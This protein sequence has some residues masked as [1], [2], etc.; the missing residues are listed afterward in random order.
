MERIIEYKHKSK[1]LR[2]IHSN[3]ARFYRK[4]NNGQ[5]IIT[6]IVSS[7]ITF[8][9]FYGISNLHV[10]INKVV[11]IDISVFEFLFNLFVF[12]L[13]VNVILHLVFYFNKKQ[14]EAE[15]AIVMLTSLVNETTDLIERARRT[16][17]IV[18]DD[19][20]DIVRHKYLT[21]TSVIPSNTDK[22]YIKAKKSL[23]EKEEE[24]HDVEKLS[25]DIFNED[26]LYKHTTILIKESILYKYLKVLKE[27]NSEMY[28]GGGAIRNLVWDEL[29]GYTPIS[30]I[31]DLD[32]IYFDK[33]SN[34]KE[35]DKRIEEQLYKKIPNIKWS[36]KNQ[37]RM[38]LWNHEEA[39]DSFEEAI[40]KW[41]E[42]CTAIAV[43]INGN[44][45]LEFIKPFGFGDLYRLIVTPTPHF[46]TKLDRFRERHTTKE[47][48]KTW[49]KLKIIE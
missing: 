24:T 3:K 14:N 12:I 40:L 5:S 33:L 38:H 17:S 26:F 37:A 21:I 1:I 39:Y 20:V 8:M 11:N 41:P 7:F 45:E 10:L 28:L 42:T 48:I 32:I 27:V 19:L 34:T 46:K 22:S 9:G 47:W 44:D 30:Q 13:F 29:H 35:H 16:P 18:T 31:K 25:V 36:V 4:I 43:R 2:Q 23:K 49:P 15:K 6:V